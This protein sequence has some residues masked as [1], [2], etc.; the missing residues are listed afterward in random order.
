MYYTIA[1]LTISIQ[2]F[3]VPMVHDV[4]SIIWFC[5]ELMIIIVNEKC[6]IIIKF[7]K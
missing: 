4:V 1:L 7:S 6:K 5:Y 2:S 3:T